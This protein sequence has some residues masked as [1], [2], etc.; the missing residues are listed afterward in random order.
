MAEEFQVSDF[1]PALEPA[2]VVDPAE[3][4]G[5]LV[6]QDQGLGLVVEAGFEGA[7]DEAL[8]DRVLLFGWSL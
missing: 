1:C 6:L 7:S 5:C 8:R 3:Q 2:A 4:P